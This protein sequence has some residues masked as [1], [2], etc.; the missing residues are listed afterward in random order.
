MGS[1]PAIRVL[2]LPGTFSSRA[3]SPSL[4]T[5]PLSRSR[6]AP[7]TVPSAETSTLLD[8]GSTAHDV[9]EMAGHRLNS[10]VAACSWAPLYLTRRGT[11][12]AARAR[13]AALLSVTVTTSRP[14]TLWRYEPAVSVPS[15]LCMVVAS[16][17]AAIAAA[18]DVTSEAWA[19][20]VASRTPAVTTPRTANLRRRRNELEILTEPPLGQAFR[21]GPRRPRGGVHWTGRPQPTATVFMVEV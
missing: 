21:D 18:L 1:P 8:V 3:A 9:P 5:Y 12:P 16:S 7:V 20:G 11:A 17:D 10:S 15:S 14:V 13:L 6:L 2:N 4:A 19:C